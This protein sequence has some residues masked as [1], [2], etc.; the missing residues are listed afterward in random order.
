MLENRSPAP[1]TETLVSYFPLPGYG[2]LPVNAF[3]LR[4]AQPMLV[5]TGLAALGDDFMESLRSAIDPQDL[6]WIWLTHTDADHIGNLQEVLAQAPQARLVTTFLG[7]G[8][9]SL[10]GMPLDRVYLLNPGQSLDLGDRLI[11]ALRPPTYDAPETTALFDEKTRILYSADSF[12]ALMQEPAENAADIEASALRDGA[13]TWATIDAPWLSS[14]EET[15][16]RATLAAIRGL[17][18]QLILSAHLPTAE[19]RMTELLCNH[20]LA[21]RE[22][23]PFEGPDQAA[24]ERM[25][26][27]TA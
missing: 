7:M 21:A 8:K 16:L 11:R 1:E 10:V 15:K 20:I 13:G 2:V 3:V 9:M 26:A 25:M 27:S 12:G 17:E 4:A 24:L 18:P 19:G 23:P 6:R 5:D 22:L 14:I